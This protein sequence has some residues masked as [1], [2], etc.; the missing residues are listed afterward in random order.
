MLSS[1]DMEKQI[2]AS[3]CDPTLKKCIQPTCVRN[4]SRYM[5]WYLAKL[6]LGIA[7]AN[8]QQGTVR[9]SWVI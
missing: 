5:Y 4:N 7:N 8:A 6:L 1:S 2:S 9:E 3:P